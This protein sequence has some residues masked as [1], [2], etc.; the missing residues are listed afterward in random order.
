M[1]KGDRENEGLQSGHIELHTKKKLSVFSIYIARGLGLHKTYEPASS[2]SSMPIFEPCMFFLEQA[3]LPCLPP[4]F[5]E[6][7]VTT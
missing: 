6:L 7:E 1:V 5:E 4:V 3:I 2:L